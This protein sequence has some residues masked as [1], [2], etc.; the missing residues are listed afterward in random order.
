VK[1]AKARRKNNMATYTVDIAL[2]LKV[3]AIEPEKAWSQANRLSGKI[4]ELA[5]TTGYN[6]IFQHV[7]E[8]EDYG[9]SQ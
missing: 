7:E 9:D 4:A 8:P 3:T 1:N 5:N 2:T 6:V